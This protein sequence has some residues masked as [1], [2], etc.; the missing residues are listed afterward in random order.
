[1][2]ILK[3]RQQGISTMVLINFLDEAMFKSGLSI[4]IMMQDL[5]L[6]HRKIETIKA[7]WDRVPQVVKELL[8]LSL[9]KNNVDTFKLSNGSV[10][11]C[12][13]SFTGDTL[14][15]MHISEMGFIANKYPE[16]AEETRTGSMQAI[17]PQNPLI[18]E[19]TARGNNLFKH[20]WDT[21][22]RNKDSMTPMSFKPV[23]LPWYNDPDCNEHSEA[24]SISA[25]ANERLDKLGVELSKSQRRFWSSKWDELGVK[26][27]QEYCA[28][29]EEAFYTNP[30]GNYYT[31]LFNEFVRG[32]DR[33]VDNLYDPALPVQLSLDL[34]RDDYTVLCF[35]Q[36]HYNTLGHWEFRIFHE[37][38]SN[39]LELQHYANYIRNLPYFDKISRVILPHDV[40]V[41][42]LTRTVTR[43]EILKSQGIKNTHVLK[44]TNVDDGIEA[45]R[46]TLHNLW[47]DKS[48]KYL[49]GCFDN[50]C[51]ARDKSRTMPDGTPVWLAT[52]ER[53]S[54]K[55]GA[56]S[57]RYMIAGAQTFTT[58]PGRRVRGGQV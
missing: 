41:T 5:A 6:A 42:D 9:V 18:I 2:I 31:Q 49:I 19:S 55:H 16:K 35:F 40:E 34:G 50:H 32:R 57:M 52:E 47:I 46:N 11:F 4:G 43:H 33:I 21:A 39:G 3:S 27:Y 12:K 53:S 48:C 24:G 23:F 30:D 1:M 13:T 56:D 36:V 20:M 8:G 45:L 44:A 15:C 54:W 26:V 28:T 37:Y 22:W 58:R 51:K 29:P 38:F 17:S 25:T 10:I 7:V 14:Q